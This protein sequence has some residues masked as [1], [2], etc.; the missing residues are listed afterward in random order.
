[1]TE[2][3]VAT[4]TASEAVVGIRGMSRLLELYKGSDLVR[5]YEIQT[6][7]KKRL[8]IG[9]Q[10]LIPPSPEAMMNMQLQLFEGTEGAKKFIR[11]TLLIGLRFTRTVA[12]FNKDMLGELMETDS[13]DLYVSFSQFRKFLGNPVLIP[14]RGH[15]KLTTPRF[16]GAS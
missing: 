5:L 8:I 10:P 1:M 7:Q 15:T 16:L 2:R 6:K 13:K 9:A 11:D 12:V 3:S 4:A 14:L